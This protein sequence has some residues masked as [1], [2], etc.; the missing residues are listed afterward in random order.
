MLKITEITFVFISKNKFV[1]A[2]FPNFRGFPGYFCILPGFDSLFSQWYTIKKQAVHSGTFPRSEATSMKHHYRRIPG[3][4]GLLRFFITVLF[5]SAAFFILTG[6]TLRDDPV[7]SHLPKPLR[8]YRPP[9]CGK[10]SGNL[11]LASG[12]TGDCIYDP[13]GKI[14]EVGG[15]KK[16]HYY[17]S[18]AISRISW[19]GPQGVDD[20]VYFSPARF[21]V[22]RSISTRN[23]AGAATLFY[24]LLYDSRGQI[25]QIRCADQGGFTKFEFSI[26]NRYD[27]QGKLTSFRV[28][29]EEDIPLYCSIYT[30]RSDGTSSI[31][32]T[33]YM[34]QEGSESSAIHRHTTYEYD[35]NGRIL[36]A[37]TDIVDQIFTPIREDYTFDDHGYLQE[38]LRKESTAVNALKIQKTEF[39]NS[40]DGRG[41][42][43]KVNAQKTEYEIINEIPQEETLLDSYTESFQYDCFGNLTKYSDGITEDRYSYA[44]LSTLQ[45]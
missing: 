33:E 37:F 24:T 30:D 1:T 20:I 41:L 45:K 25:K 11:Y 8:G 2:N 32:A 43:I 44:I 31:S 3:R 4:P 17:P 28:Y 22:C 26:D 35:K 13:E 40:Y 12:P 5:F 10:H 21:P 39:L 6:F 16:Y 42:L 38:I 23:K 9:D 34:E 7:E 27:D 14:L 15:H 19:V 29:D 18:G 36:Y